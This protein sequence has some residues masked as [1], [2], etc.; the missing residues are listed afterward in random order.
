MEGERK[1]FVTECY[2]PDVDD[3][4][5]AAL[6]ERIDR[7]IAGLAPDRA[8][9]YLGSILLRE[10]EVVLCQFEGPAG[11]VSHVAELAEVPFERILATAHSPWQ[12]S[13]T[14]DAN[15]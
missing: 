7:V 4:E 3:A 14:R 6:D 1:S 9:R 8:V 12:L 15:S 10:D 5:L 13:A 11:N 2:W